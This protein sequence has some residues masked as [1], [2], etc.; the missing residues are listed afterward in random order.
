MFWFQG[1]YELWRLLQPTTSPTHLHGLLMWFDKTTCL[2]SRLWDTSRD[3][4]QSLLYWSNHRFPVTH[5]GFLNNR[6]KQM[7]E[8]NVTVETENQRKP[9]WRSSQ[10]SSFPQISFYLSSSMPVS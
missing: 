4:G 6:T 8:V 2:S 3:Q 10:F 1:Q 7:Y 9:K 5:V